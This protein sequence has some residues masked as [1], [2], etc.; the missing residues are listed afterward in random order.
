MSFLLTEGKNDVDIRP[1]QPPS[2]LSPWTYSQPPNLSD[3]HSAT[4]R[5]RAPQPYP[6]A[7]PVSSRASCVRQRP[8]PGALSSAASLQAASRSPAPSL[9]STPRPAARC[10][11]QVVQQRSRV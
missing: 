11:Q 7:C 3:H 5:P 9:A 6:L 4:R 2:L 10:L 1:P 8:L